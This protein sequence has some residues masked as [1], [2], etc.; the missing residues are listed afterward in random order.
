MVVPVCTQ[1]EAPFSSSAEFTLRFLN[2][3]AL[4]VIIGQPVKLALSE[5]SRER[6]G[7]VAE[8]TSIAGLQGGEAIPGRQ[9]NEFDLCGIVEDGAATGW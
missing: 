8:S 3:E 5:V 7:G 9:G 2:Q 4:A 6:P 1:T